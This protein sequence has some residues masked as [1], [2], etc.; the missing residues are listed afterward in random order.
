MAGFGVGFI[1][2]CKGSVKMSREV[3]FSGDSAIDDQILNNISSILGC[4]EGSITEIYPLKAGLTNDSW[5]FST[6]TGEYVYR[7]PGIG[8]EQ[9][10][11]REAEHVAQVLA[12]DL[13]LD[14][15]FIHSDMATGWKISRFLSNCANLDPHDDAQVAEAMRIA[16]TLHASDMRLERE[17]D[18]W[19]ESRRYEQILSADHAI[20]ASPYQELVSEMTRLAALVQ[21]DEAPVCLTHNDFFDLNL[22]RDESGRVHLID[23][24]YAG[25]GDYANDFGTFVV[26]SKL[27]V[28]EAGRALAHYFG[29]DATLE[30]KRHNFGMVALAGWCWYLWSLVKE[31]EGDD[32]GDWLEVYLSYARDFL[33]LALDLYGE[34]TG[35]D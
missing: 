24:E 6:P 29:R 32:V 23:W 12:H 18:F 5:H 34:S 35:Q 27:S 25:T 14:G 30:E 19:D 2:F 1:F 8:T 10:I 20:E 16:H 7:H 13:G 26:T 33:P 17:F 15:T 28:E 31:E 4:Q 3:I 9:L 21:A 22:L 11:D